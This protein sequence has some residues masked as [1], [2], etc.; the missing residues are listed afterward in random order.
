MIGLFIFIDW[1]VNANL[2]Q[3]YYAGIFALTLILLSINSKKKLID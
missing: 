3:P 1:N 2:Y